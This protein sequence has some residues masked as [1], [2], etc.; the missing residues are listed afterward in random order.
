MAT[1]TSTI[2]LVD[3]MTPTLNK[4]SKAIDSV[5]QR[6]D[7][8]GTSIERANNR[9]L[10]SAHRYGNAMVKYTDQINFKQNQFNSTLGKT[11]SVANS[12][13]STFRR[14]L[15]TVGMI[16]G[17]RAMIDTA[18]T[19]MN[20]TARINNLTGNLAETQHYL[21][22]IYAAAQRSRGSFIDMTNSVGKL[23][24]IARDAFGSVEEMI[25]FTEL[26]NKLFVLSGS[27]AAESSNAMYQLTQAMA[28]GKLQG[29]EMRSILENAPLLAQKIA[30]KLGITTGQLK[31][32]GAKGKI[33]AEV[34]K[35][36][37]FDSADEI[38]EK[39]ENMP[40]TIG[41]TWTE[42][43]NHALNAFRPVIDRVQQ[44]I[45]SPA[46][47]TFK[48]KVFS[49]INTIANGIIRLFELFETPRIQNAI[50]R[51]CAAFGVL[52]DIVSWIG[53]AM[54]Q[55]AIWIA[56]NW[57]WIAPIVYTVAWAFLVYKAAIM[58]VTVAMWAYNAAQFVA[59]LIAGTVVLTTFG[60]VVFI[61]VALIAILYLGVAAWNHFTGQTVSATG[62]LFGAVA[63]VIACIIDLFVFLWDIFM[64][65]IHIVIALGKAILQVVVDTVQFISALLANILIFAT[66]LLVSVLV[67]VVEM[68]QALVN[69]LIWIVKCAGVFLVNILVFAGNVLITLIAVVVGFVSIV[70]GTFAFALNCVI[71]VIRNIGSGLGQ[72]AAIIGAY[73]TQAKATVAIQF[74]GIV[75]AFTSSINSMIQGAGEGVKQLLTPFVNFANKCIDIFNSIAEAWN[76]SLGSWSTTITNPFTGTKYNLGFGKITTKAHVSVNDAISVGKT[77]GDYADGKLGSAISEYNS[78]QSI[79]NSGVNWGKNDL[80]NI[81]DYFDIGGVGSLISS[82]LN[83]FD[84]FEYPEYT[85]DWTSVWGE[86][87]KVWLG[88]LPWLD[89][90]GAFESDKYG[91]IWGDLT[92]SLGNTWDSTQ[93]KNPIDAFKNWGDKGAKLEGGIAGP[94]DGIGGILEGLFGKTDGS[95]NNTMQDAIDKAFGGTGSGSG[96]DIPSSVE[97]LLD[98]YS[99]TGAGSGLKDAL[100]SIADNTG[101]TAGSTGNI[102]D[103]LNMA[104]EELELLRKLAEQEVINRF[105]TAEIHVDMTNNNNINSKMDLD[106]IVTH[107]SN[108]LYEELGVVAS[109]VHY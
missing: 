25:A 38:E 62:I 41:Q 108:K 7:N 11:K 9:A 5:S 10:A 1:I 61:I 81:G 12:V 63:F 42:I 26:M 85:A 37:L 52:W 47:E 74:W 97:D 96:K 107:L 44:F 16:V 75:S 106:G 21:D 54:V 48:N 22:A 30:D 89:L 102:E 82:A 98:G 60:W 64:S 83:T 45:N 43:A 77:I 8:I 66:M 27:S 18:D 32:L 29:D 2:K 68:G 87:G 24:T 72:C 55:V 3:Q 86:L 99:P 40:K 35:E 92:N 78:A 88:D 91:K 84:Y 94:V 46:F 19:M 17:V 20:S 103:T 90:G 14:I 65:I 104:E 28:A 93:Y 23:G 73:F 56:D 50:S 109:G 100:G 80:P 33:T 53:N 15:A 4:I 39:F 105:T 95:V 76:N 31:D 101:K 58:V 70:V 67:V 34:I 6:S 69:T 36:A 59:G 51:I 57:N 49:I 79:I 13:A 71:T